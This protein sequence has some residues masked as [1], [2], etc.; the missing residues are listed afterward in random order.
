MKINYII[1]SLH[2]KDS[3]YGYSGVALM[4]FS[5]IFANIN[6]IIGTLA[7]I[8]GLILIIYNIKIKIKEFK[9]KEIE[10]KNLELNEKDK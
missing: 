3:Y 1:E 4:W 7:T 5:S 10:L 8:G 9:I 6:T 2:D